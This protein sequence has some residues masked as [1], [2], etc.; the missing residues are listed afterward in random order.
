MSVP[1]F[2]R[3]IPQRYNLI[4]NKCEI[5]SKVYFPPRES[6]P[7]CRRKSIGHIKDLK[8]SGKGEVF[9]YSIIH[10]SSGEFEEQVP[11][12]IA[13]IKLDEGPMIT[14][15]IVDCDPD[16]VKIGMRVE[17]TFRQIQQDGYTGALYYGYKFKKV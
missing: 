1:R 3:E 10:V 15:Q 13:I 12:P 11:Y 9:T 5:C 16:C 6:C 8:L 7:V 14:A 4:G 17:S 2:W